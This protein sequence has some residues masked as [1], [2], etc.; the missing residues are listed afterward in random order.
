MENRVGKQQSALPVVKH[1]LL[2]ETFA[3]HVYWVVEQNVLFTVGQTFET[4]K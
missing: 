4:K 2:R 3:L 1:V